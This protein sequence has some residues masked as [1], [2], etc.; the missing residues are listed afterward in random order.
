VPAPGGRPPFCHE[1]AERLA[2]SASPGTGRRHGLQR[3]CRIFGLARS[4]A[5]YLKAREA[6]PPDQRPVPRRRGPVGA[7]TDD[8]LVGHIRRALAESPFHGEGYRK[9]WARLRHRGIRTASERVRRL[10]RE[11][12][13]QAPRRGG[14]P[15]GPKA[16]DGVITT[17][18]PDT[19]WG[20]DMTTTVTTGQ[21][22]VH[23]FV[24]VDHCTCECVG[25]HA[26]KS[27]DR[28][29]ALEPLRQGVREHFGRFEAKVA[30]GLTIRHDHGSNYLS[31]DFQRELTFLGMVSSP[32][33]VREPEGNGCAE[34]F[35]RTL[36]EQLLWIR[37]FATVAELVGALGE[38]KRT[39]NERWLIRRHGHRTPSE[40]RRDL[41]D[42]E[43]AA[44]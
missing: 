41:G 16:H 43:S 21:G 44:A 30:E 22:T 40:V 2:R 15:H 17:E 28:F 31:D 38:F 4:T 18:E 33:F 13:L 39:Y 5:Y 24:A 35:I 34:R 29:E 27:G 6:I 25:L 14:H 12:H 26:A 9:V 10:M 42:S 11:H 32:S 20:T 3:V 7:A 23:V 19:M 36:K 37:T 8:E 1:E